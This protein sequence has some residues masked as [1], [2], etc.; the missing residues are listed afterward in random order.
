MLISFVADI[1][2]AKIFW[3]WKEGQN[4]M[5]LAIWVKQRRL[6]FHTS[7]KLSSGFYTKQRLFRSPTTA[8]SQN[9]KLKIYSISY[10]CSSHCY[11]SSRCSRCITPSHWLEFTSFVDIWT[12]FF[13]LELMHVLHRGNYRLFKECLVSMLNDNEKTTAVLGTRCTKNLTNK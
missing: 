4:Q 9:I 2:E 6:T 3:D 12:P 1:L 7:Q 5:P 10:P 11:Q 13:W 8:V